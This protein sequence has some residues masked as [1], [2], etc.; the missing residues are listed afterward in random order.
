MASYLGTDAKLCLPP[1]MRKVQ[2]SSCLIRKTRS[3]C[4]VIGHARQDRFCNVI[5]IHDRQCSILPCLFGAWATLTGD[6]LPNAPEHLVLQFA[7][8]WC[9]CCMGIKSRKIRRLYVV[10][11]GPPWVSVSQSPPMNHPSMCRPLVEGN[12]RANVS[13]GLTFSPLISLNFDSARNKAT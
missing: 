5:S 3:A 11:P 10:P 8:D 12:S 1:P 4:L 6:V 9:T 2:S 13:S 7:L